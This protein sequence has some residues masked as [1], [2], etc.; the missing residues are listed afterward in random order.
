MQREF[1]LTTLV[2]ERQRV[3]HLKEWIA[4]FIQGELVNTSRSGATIS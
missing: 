3:Q 2:G 1:R 4:I